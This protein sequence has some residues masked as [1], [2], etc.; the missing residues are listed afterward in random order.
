MSLYEDIAAIVGKERATESNLDRI[1]YGHDLAP[2]PDELLKGLGVSKPDVVIRPDKVSHVVDVMKYALRR[3]VPVTPRGGGSWGLGGVLPI[4]GGIVIDLSGMNHIIELNTEDEYVTIETGLEWKR[5]SDK[6]KKHGFHVGAYPTSAPVATVG[7][8]I[9]T[10]G[11]SGIGVSQYGTIG[12]QIISL[13]V[14]LPDGRVVKTN[15][16]D[17]WFFVGSEGTLGIV[18]EATLKIFKNNIIKHMLFGFD[19]LDAGLE[20]IIKLG[21]L[22]PYYFAASHICVGAPNMLWSDYCFSDRNELA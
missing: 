2:L 6:I 21:Q 8:Y 1:C 14:V 9:S 7:G 18:C 4:E 10:G 5:L 17:S 20:A 13:K 16:W 11:S 3:N 22:N 15:P 19:S 12:D